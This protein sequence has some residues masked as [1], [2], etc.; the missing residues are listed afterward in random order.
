VRKNLGVGGR[1]RAEEHLVDEMPGLE[2]TVLYDLSGR[3][4]CPLGAPRQGSAWAGGDYPL[5]AQGAAWAGGDCPPR[6]FWPRRSSSRS[7]WARIC[8]G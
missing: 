8:F 7:T 5:G 2:E 4:D 6:V 1:R 3:G